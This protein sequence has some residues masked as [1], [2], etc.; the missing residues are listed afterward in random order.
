MHRIL[1][2]NDPFSWKSNPLQRLSSGLKSGRTSKIAL[3][4][5]IAKVRS[6]SLL[7]D[8][9]CFVLFSM[10]LKAVNIVFYPKRVRREL[11]FKAYPHVSGWSLISTMGTCP[12][13][14]I[15]IHTMHFLAQGQCIALQS[16]HAFPSSR[17]MHSSDM[18]KLHV[19]S[20]THN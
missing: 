20:P 12:A 11:P 19:F 8:I 16:H 4:P 1:V 9:H 2:P 15:Y 14:N 13:S 10:R 18:P 17:Y 5:E 6:R 7:I 3:K